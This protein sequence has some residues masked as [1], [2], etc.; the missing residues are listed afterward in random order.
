VAVVAVAVAG[1]VITRPSPKPACV[2]VTG[3]VQSLAGASPGFGDV[4]AVSLIDGSIAGVAQVTGGRYTVCVPPANYAIVSRAER[5]SGGRSDETYTAATVVNGS[6]Q[7]NV[8]ASLVGRLFGAEPAAAASGGGG[9]VAM[10]RIP[11]IQPA[12]FNM[13]PN[14]SATGG[15][16]YGFVDPCLKSGRRIIAADPSVLDFMKQEHARAHSHRA[17]A[18]AP[19]NVPTPDVVISGN[20]TVGEDGKP[21]ADITITDPSTGRSSTTSSW[22]VTPVSSPSRASVTPPAF[23]VRSAR[24]SR[25]VTATR[26]SRRPQRCG[27]HRV[28]RRLLQPARSRRPPERTASP[29]AAP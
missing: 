17:T 12:D 4:E 7:L 29:T 16:D 20:V 19:I 18:M 6:T 11:P 24:D 13:A 14:A 26:S 2:G 28:H 5:L 23:S 1:I 27:S 15:I 8:A 3:Q 25:R 9:V 21:V 10:S 22:P